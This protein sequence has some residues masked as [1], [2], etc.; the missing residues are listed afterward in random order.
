VSKPTK[1][2][3]GVLRGTADANIG[4]EDLRG[5]LSHLGFTERIR[6]SHHISTRA[7]VAEIL[8]IQS[9]GGKA[10]A[11]Q[12]RQVRDVIVTYGLAQEPEP[13]EE[14]PPRE[15]PGPVSAEGNNG[16]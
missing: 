3:N 12:V 9:R 14:E 11:Y 1:T 4:F 15:G 10:K 13:T 7:G 5:L 6:G 16:N 2:L 8:N